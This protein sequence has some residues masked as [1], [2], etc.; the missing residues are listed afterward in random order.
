M[1]QGEIIRKYRLLKSLSQEKL[2]EKLNV[3]CQS[4]SNWENGKTAIDTG[5]LIELSRELGVSTDILTGRQEDKTDYRWKL[6]NRFF[7]EQKMKTFLKGYLSGKNYYQSL[8]ALEYAC[9]KHNATGALRKIR[10][11]DAG[12]PYI[13]HPLTLACHAIAM[14]VDSDDL[15]TA[16]LLHDVC[17]DCGV[18]PDEIPD[19]SDAAREIVRLVTKVKTDK[20]TAPDYYENILKSPAA[21]L[22]KC[23]DRCNN[24]SMMAMGFS[25]AKIKEYIEETEEKIYPMLSILKAAP[26]YNNAYW[27]LSYQIYACIETAKNFMTD[28]E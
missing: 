20:G 12:T 11:S 25:K 8:N 13:N 4:V 6:K 2:A 24:V 15:I 7:N 26:E 14:G 18:T 19:I 3:S 28:F 10:Y 27:L 21:C 17:E 16:L 9:E 22:V 1:P 5:H 23:I